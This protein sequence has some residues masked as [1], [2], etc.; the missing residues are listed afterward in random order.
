M[1]NVDTQTIEREQDIVQPGEPIAQEAP[2]PQ[3]PATPA[4]GGLFER[5]SQ[6]DATIGGLR[7][8]SLA[9][10]M[11]VTKLMSQAGPAV[12]AHCR[13]NVG[14]C[15]ALCLQALEWKMSPFAVANKSYITNDRIN[16]ESQLVHAVIEARAPLKQRLGRRYK[17]EGDNRVCIVFGTFKGETEVRE[18]ESPPLSQIRP[19]F[20]DKKDRDGNPIRKGSPLWD[21]K[22]DVQLFYDTSRDFGRIYC[23]DVLLGIYTP[24][25]VEQYGGEIGTEARDITTEVNIAADAAGLH[26]RLAAAQKTGEG[27][28]EGVVEVGLNQPGEAQEASKPT[29]AATTVAKEPEKRTDEPPAG[30]A[31]PFGKAKPGSVPKS[32]KAEPSPTPLARPT[33]G[34]G[35][36]AYARK[37]MAES[38][39]PDEVDTRWKNEFKLRKACGVGGGDAGTALVNMKNARLKELGR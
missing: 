17:G 4:E 8:E 6:I 7:I 27:F 26:E 29:P 22:P 21:K 32:K 37:W 34:P 31:K 11:D 38:D 19:P 23:P 10:V 12:P 5:A 9:Q 36:L 14:V 13:G 25:E 2:K 16:Y 15:F 35:Y 20:G 39:D 28:R 30:K 1:T 24:D 3:L 18:H 33:D